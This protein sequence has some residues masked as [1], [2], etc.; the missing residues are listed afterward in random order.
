MW[1][2]SKVFNYHAEP[3]LAITPMFL[4]HWLLTEFLMEIENACV[5]V[6]NNSVFSGGAT[7]KGKR[8]RKTCWN[9]TWVWEHLCM[10]VV[11]CHYSFIFCA[12]KGSS[13]SLFNNRSLWM[14]M[15]FMLSNNDL[16]CPVVKRNVNFNSFLHTTGYLQFSSRMSEYLKGFRLLSL[17]LLPEA[18]A[19]RWITIEKWKQH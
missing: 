3:K 16:G 17:L 2:T 11:L 14:D 9:G 4:F 7:A 18:T 13:G 19:Y 1:F 10:S 12:T 8:R 15:V 5:K 6:T